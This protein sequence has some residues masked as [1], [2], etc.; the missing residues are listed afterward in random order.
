MIL[1]KIRALEYSYVLPSPSPSPL[2]HWQKIS[3]QFFIVPDFILFYF[4]L[5]IYFFKQFHLQDDHLHY[6]Q[7]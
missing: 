7:Y 5:F 4:I 2:P 3:S 6:L 1:D